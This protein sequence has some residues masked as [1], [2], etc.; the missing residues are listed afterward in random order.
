MGIWRYPPRYL[1]GFKGICIPLVAE[2]IVFPIFVSPLVMERIFRTCRVY[3]AWELLQKNGGSEP[4]AA[5]HG[6]SPNLPERHTLHWN[7]GEK[8]RH[9]TK[10]VKDR[11]TVNRYG[12][13]IEMKDRDC[14]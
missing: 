5:W 14:K 8:T 6:Q 11:D 1:I 10:M 7:L 9:N 12:M 13:E 4:P 3:P 2:V